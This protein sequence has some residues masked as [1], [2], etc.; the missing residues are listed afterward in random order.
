MTESQQPAF[1]D[2]NDGDLKFSSPTENHVEPLVF[3]SKGPHT[4]TF[5]MLHGRG[6]TGKGFGPDFMLA[7]HSSG[8]SLQDLFPGMKFIFPTAKRRRMAG[9]RVTINQWFDIVSLV[10]P[11]LRNET[12]V[13]GL[14][15]S[16]TFIHEIIRKEMESIPCQK[17]II[18]G[19]SQGC[20][21]A[22]Y[23]LLTFEP[24]QDI[25]TGKQSSLGATVGMSG[26]LPFCTA[27]HEVLNPPKLADGQDNPFSSKDDTAE[28]HDVGSNIE[29][30]NF[31]RDTIDLLPLENPH[32]AAMHT[33]VFLG[34]G[35]ADEQVDVQL[36]ERA[37]AALKDLGMNVVWKPYKDFYHWYKEPDE[38]DDMVEFLCAEL[39][40]ET[41]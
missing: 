29:A 18:G 4:S 10:D 6:D 14:L 41:A 17:I 40:L 7:E 12:Q 39:G 34:H 22:L 26:W 15:E 16:A 31:L 30:I 37:V 23:A 19:L 33:P 28:K 20:A 8:K 35:T 9:S 1:S 2:D 21:T 36:G 11:S 25:V 13:E 32:P 27:I 5:I 38:I 3:P 24:G